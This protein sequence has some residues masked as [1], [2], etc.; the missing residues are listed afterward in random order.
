MLI[1]Q[2]DHASGAYVSSRLADPDPLNED[3]WLVPFFSTD[4]G[5]PEVSRN[6]WPFFVDGAW[7]LRPD[8][9]G[10]MLY[11]QVDGTAAE[12]LL[13]GITPEEAGLTTEPR[14]SDEY[15]WVDGA[16]QIDPA[17]V[18]ARKRTAAMAE[19]DVRMAKARAEN[20]GKGDAYAA[21]LLSPAEVGVF[22]AWAEYQMALARVVNDPQ[23]PEVCNW[24]AE[25]DVAEAA[26][27]GVADAAAEEAKRQAALESTRPPVS[28]PPKA[29][30]P[31][32]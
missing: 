24:P 1:H 2:Y 29:D 18:A 28:E 14:P 25:P 4:S 31:Q 16:W 8:Y 32:E 10:R 30:D 5:L 11:R 23:F 22:K 26:A 7:E 19:F 20:L 13:P 3:R 9:R 6:T 27:K 12:I 17:V 15:H 21:N